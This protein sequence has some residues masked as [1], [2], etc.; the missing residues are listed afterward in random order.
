MDYRTWNTDRWLAVLGLATGLV[1]I[2]YGV[3]VDYE[4]RQVDRLDYNI[5]PYSIFSHST[6]YP[7]VAVM[8]TG[9]KI[10]DTNIFE[11]QITVWNSGNTTIKDSEIRTPLTIA[12]DDSIKIYNAKIIRSKGDADGFEIYNGK[13]AASIGWKVFD[14]GDAIRVLLLHSGDAKT[15]S[16][17]G[18][19][20]PSASIMQ[21]Q[22]YSVAGLIFLG[23]FCSVMAVI[24][25]PLFC[26]FVPV[27]AGGAILHRIGIVKDKTTAEEVATRLTNNAVKYGWLPILVVS[28]ATAYIVLTNEYGLYDNSPSPIGLS[29]SSAQGD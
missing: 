14:P 1:A 8:P 25:L 9:E 3:K 11:T 29:Q 22:A 12:G 21:Y 28:L 10:G 4:H 27:S 15:F 18:N 17:K 20:G 24:V 7:V 5:A 6:F 26:I 16:V 13:N 2:L 23:V 19:L